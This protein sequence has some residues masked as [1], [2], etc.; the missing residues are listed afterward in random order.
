MKKSNY[1]F[2]ELTNRWC[3]QKGRTGQWIMGETDIHP[4]TGKFAPYKGLVTI[5]RALAKKRAK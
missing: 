4:Q 5:K 3:T 1:V 2:N